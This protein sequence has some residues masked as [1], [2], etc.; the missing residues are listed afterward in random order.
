MAAIRKE[1]GSGPAGNGRTTPDKR[2]CQ[3]RS[4]AAP[5][6]KQGDI[7][8]PDRGQTLFHLDQGCI[9]AMSGV[10]RDIPDKGVDGNPVPPGIVGGD[11]GPGNF[12]RQ[13]PGH[14]HGEGRPG[15]TVQAPDEQ[16]ANDRPA[17]NP[18]AKRYPGGAEGR[19]IHHHQP[20]EPF[21][22]ADGAAEAD[23]PAPVMD[24]QGITRDMQMV[25]SS[26]RLSICRARV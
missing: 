6:K 5:E 3:N 10:K 8:L 25:R 12:F 2:P 4:P 20:L 26:S 24:D 17:A 21:R 18:D 15:K 23:C 9:A 19:G 14:S 11:I 1:M 16:R 7:P 22:R 13:R